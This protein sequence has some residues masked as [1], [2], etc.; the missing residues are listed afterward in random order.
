M[1]FSC[2]RFLSLSF[3]AALALPAQEEAN[4]PVGE[5]TPEMAKRGV[6]R[7]W[8]GAGGEP[9]AHS[10]DLVPK[11]ATAGLPFLIPAP[12]EVYPSDRAIAL[13][14]IESYDLA[15]ELPGEAARLTLL[16]IELRKRFEQRFGARP[17]RTPAK[18]APL[19]TFALDGWHVPAGREKLAA[20]L[21]TISDPEGYIISA[22]RV[23][24]R[25]SIV[26]LGK[27]E[28]GLW[29]ALATVGQLAVAREGKL[30]LPAV[31]VIDYPHMQQRALLIDLGGQGY[32]VGPSRWGFE[33][34]RQYVDWMVDHKF[35][36]LYIEFIGSGRLMGNLN[37]D[38][39]EWIGF[40]LA[41]TTY[42]QL[43]CRDRPIK[44]WDEAKQQVVADRY[45]APNVEKDFC[46]ELIDYAQ[47]RGIACHLL[48][49]YDYFA[50]QLPYL[51]GVPANDPSHRG[52]N[53][54]YD[55]ILREIVQRYDNASGVCFITIEN[56]HVPPTMVDEVTR[57]M[58]EGR[59]IVKAINPRMSV[60]VLND[61]LEW[62]PREETERFAANVPADLYQ[63]YTP[64]AA[65]HNKAW[66]RIYGHTLRYELYTQYA[67]NH[68]AYVFPDRVKHEIQE[69][70][71]NGYRR[72]VTQ[73]WYA[74]AFMLNFAAL[75]EM[76]WNSTGRPLGEY[77]T[78]Q[79]TAVFGAAAAPHL[80]EA[81]AHTRFDRRLDIAARMLLRDKPESAYSFWDMYTLTNYPGGI[82]DAWLADL[83]ADAAASLAAAEKARPL[84]TASP[85]A[86]EMLDVTTSSAERR[87]HLATSARH[88]LRARAAAAKGDRAG[89]L[90]LMDQAL[91]EGKK[92]DRAA[93]KL[94]IEY[95]MAVSDDDVLALYTK[96]QGELAK[97]RH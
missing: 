59:A 39:G 6:P 29:R 20:R 11:D 74:D 5:V 75:A 77:W 48:I 73:A 38:A 42:P 76:S 40:P 24:D 90:Q 22:E 44:R 87:L 54:V 35:N 1:N 45:T 7:A 97:G 81:F 82:T 67:W 56:K 83:E 84:I 21:K 18:N 57:R 34:W 64:H 10:A 79:L 8:V 65:P 91:A 2:R 69:A 72:V 85:V 30:S 92:L 89:A 55:T 28:A 94:G 26:V 14:P 86:R 49:G 63:F 78:G 46:R 58:H 61:Y 51:L 4:R 19:L 52:A 31:E 96:Y 70:Y 71:I 25:D 33:R 3:L 47:A 36:S 17:T 13:G 9:G 50:N 37:P 88:Y 43:V 95:P 12:Q 60:G 32:M 27:S 93:T 62:R 66:P 53:K 23:G 80:R 41:L 16:P 68:V 15:I